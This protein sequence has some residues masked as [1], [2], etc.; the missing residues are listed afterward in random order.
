[1]I[2]NFEGQHAGDVIMAMP[3]ITSLRRSG[4][5]V[6]VYVGESY[7]SFLYGFDLD[8]V[9][10]PIGPIL[11]A[12]N[13]P[14]H[15]TEF[16]LDYFRVEPVRMEIQTGYAEPSVVLSPD[17][18]IYQRRMPTEFWN[19][20]IDW[21]K[22]RGVPVTMIGPK[23]AVNYNSQ[24][25]LG[26]EFN[27]TGKQSIQETYA[28]LKHALAVITTD[29]GTSHLSDALNDVTVTAFARDNQ[30]RYAPYWNRRVV[31]TLD[32][33]LKELETL[34]NNSTNQ[35]LRNVEPRNSQSTCSD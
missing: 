33:A 27:Q 31:K 8:Y 6:E 19:G 7:K 34:I 17:S 21:C 10:A 18:R 24:F 28:T 30:E 1:M 22:D 20:I 25:N 12:K 13:I 9:D 15:A 2:L 3:V 11:S 29:T 14:G 35:G 26:T 4:V 32:G 16:W 5:D 23:D